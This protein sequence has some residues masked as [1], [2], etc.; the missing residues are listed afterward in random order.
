MGGERSLEKR[1]RQTFLRPAE[2][3]K[4][5]QKLP[6]LE[7]HKESCWP[8]RL[9]GT[10]RS[11]QVSRLQL[12]SQNVAS[13]LSNCISIHGDKLPCSLT[14]SAHFLNNQCPGNNM[15]TSKYQPVNAEGKSI[16]GFARKS[17]QP[18]RNAGGWDW[19]KGAG[20][21]RELMYPEF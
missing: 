1:Q 13:C 14:N 15:R 19:G 3:E 18:E 4:D 20:L 6:G 9:T 5:T 21:R 17:P 12:W 8:G 16:T 11:C 10:Q 7:K 2:K